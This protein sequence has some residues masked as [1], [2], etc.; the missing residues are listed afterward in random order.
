[1]ELSAPVAQ[2][3]RASGYEPA[4]NS[5]QVVVL[6]ALTSS[7]PSLACSKVAPK[8]PQNSPEDFGSCLFLGP[9]PHIGWLPS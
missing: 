1:M 5:I 4:A 6:V 2:L 7:E 3:D 9:A 8:S